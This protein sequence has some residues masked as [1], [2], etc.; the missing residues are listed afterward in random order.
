MIDISKI[1]YTC[2]FIDDDTD[3]VIYVKATVGVPLVGHD[4]RLSEDD[5][6]QVIAVVWCFDERTYHN[7]RIN[8]GVKKINTD[9]KRG[10]QNG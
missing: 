4:I 2:H 5:F 9:Y 8:V 7:Q 10:E 1:K 3:R 6:Y